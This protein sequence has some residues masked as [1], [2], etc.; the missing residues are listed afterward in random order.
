MSVRLI[1]SSVK[2]KPAIVHLT[3]GIAQ[4]LPCSPETNLPVSWRFSDSILPRGPRHTVLSQGLIIRPS[5]SDAGLYTCETVETVNSKVHRKTVVQYHVQVQDTNAV[6]R[7]LRAAVITLAA[8]ASFLMFLTR[9]QLKAKKQNHTGGGNENRSN[10]QVIAARP[11]CHY[12]QTTGPRT[13]KGLVHCDQAEGRHTGANSRSDA[14]TEKEPCV[15]AGGVISILILPG[16]SAAKVAEEEVEADND[17]CYTVI[18]TT[19]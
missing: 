10:N 1:S 2:E 12:D 4:F 14:A 13:E 8:F 16:G 5:Y 7:N 15:E 11:F 18:E 17:N 6:V 19:E 3:I 9:R